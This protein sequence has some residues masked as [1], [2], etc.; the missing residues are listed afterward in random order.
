MTAPK[1]KRS[2]GKAIRTHRKA[3]GH[4][5]EA[6]ADLVGLHRT[7]VGAI[8]RGERNPSLDNLLK[9]ADELRVPLSRLLREAE[10]SDR[11]PG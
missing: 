10:E 1:I 11:D 5:Q 3:L 7:Y 2:L 8:E 4:S 6:F 9:I